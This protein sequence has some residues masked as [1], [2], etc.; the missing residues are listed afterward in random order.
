MKHRQR[1]KNK[2]L[3]LRMQA[4]E[5]IKSWLPVLEADRDYDYY[6]LEIIIK[7]KLKKMAEH[8]T[9]GAYFDNYQRVVRTINYAVYLIDRIH[10]N[11]ES[12]RLNEE[13]RA[14][15][16]DIKVT[17]EEVEG[18]KYKALRFHYSKVKTPEEQELAETESGVNYAMAEKKINELYARLFRHMGKYLRGWWT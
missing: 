8:I 12:K 13:F 10:S 14:K 1:K 4:N 11:V 17:F 3:R 5:R 15:W 9:K 18:S 7:H 2:K 16:G 6:F